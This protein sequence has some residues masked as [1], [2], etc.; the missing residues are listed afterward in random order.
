MFPTPAQREAIDHRGGPLLILAGAGTGKTATLAGRVESVIAS[1]TAPERICLLTFSR[2]AAT[3]MLRRVDPAVAARVWGGTFHA[4][5]HRLLRVHARRLG[6]DPMFTVVDEGDATEL[7]AL[8]RHEGGFSST[9]GKR[10][11]RAETLAK[12]ASRVANTQQPLSTVLADA[13]PW[14]LDHVDGVRTVL[15]GYLARKRAQSLVDFD[16]I[17]L[18]WRALGLECAGAF[19][20]VLVDEYQDTNA[21]QAD[22]VAQL[23][24]DGRGLAVVGDDAQAIYSFRS[25]TPDNIRGFASRFPGTTIVRL[26][27]NHRSTAPILAVANS[28]LEEATGA[29]P[30]TLRTSR[31]DGRVPVL[32]RTID[33]VA[34]AT[35]VCD[36]VLAHREDGVDLHEQAV[37]FRA[38][39]HADVLEVELRRRNIPYVKYGGLRFLEAAHVRDLLALLRI[40]DNPRDELAWFRALRMVDGIG[41]ARA[42]RLMGLIGVRDESDALAAFVSMP[43]GDG[44]DELRAALADCR[45]TDAAPGPDVDR[46]RRFLDPSV[47]RRYA[48]PAARLA[49]LDALAA[50]ARRAPT[51]TALLADLTLDPPGSTSDLAGAGSVD[52]D[53]LVLSTVHSAKGGEWRVVHVIHASDGLF[54]ADLATG[55]PAS[56]EE[57]RRLFYVAVTRA[58]DVLEV[59]ATLRYYLRPKTLADG[60]GY[61]QLSRFLSP[62]VRAHMDERDEAGLTSAA[63]ATPGVAAT[64]GVAAVDGLLASLLG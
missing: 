3:E 41:Q 39:H 5:G 32:R 30:K 55:T 29:M 26:E 12:I 35:A 10:F 24:P 59:N 15:H 56:I 9:D 11:P 57:E 37:L 63:G 44:L 34:Q 50:V 28:V 38:S 36:S 18:L 40:L 21:V 27:D 22:I 54:P 51:R 13:F 43:S 61:G 25:A 52:D 19:E 42:T 14:A 58:R 20:H 64:S 49:D 1:G 8:V 47:A 2:R 60:H 53:W 16:D 33:D 17:L 6:L 7:I 23:C 31:T 48:S 46:L 4:V 62:A 45:A